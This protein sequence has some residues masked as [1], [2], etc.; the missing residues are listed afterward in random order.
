MP[1]WLPN[2]L[3]PTTALTAAGVAVPAL[4]LLYFLKLRRQEVA[5]SSTLL[6]KKAIQD[7]QVNA[8]FQKLRRNL[9]LILQMLLLVLMLLALA[10]PVINMMRPA[11]EMT[12]ILIDRSASMQTVEEDGRTRLDIAKERARSLVG[13]LD[14]GAS[15]MVIA[16][17]DSAE[18]VQ[19]FT[20]DA[21]A[22]RRAID[23][24]QPTDRPSRLKLA[25]QLAE[26]QSNF[27]PEQL[28][29]NIRPDVFVFSDGRVLDGD[30]LRITGEVQYERIG[31]P[32]TPNVGIVAMSARRNYERPQEVQVFARLANY[33]PEVVDADVQFSVAMIDPA[34]P[35]RL[36]YQVVR[37][38][39]TTLIP[40]H[41]TPEQR[42]QAE[43]EGITPRD[44]VEFTLELTTAGV[45]RLQHLPRT[46]DALAADD[47]A[48]VVVPPP[49]VLRVALVTEGNYF[50]EK[51]LDSLNLRDPV[52][53]T[54]QAYERSVGN[55]ES[56][57][58]QFD[59]IIF[60]RYAPPRPDLLPS[61]GNFLW[62]GA[63]PD[64]LGLKVMQQ[65]GQPVR[66]EDV[67]VLDWQRDHPMLRHLSLGRLY[68]A[69]ALRFD[70]PLETQRLIE[71]ISGP[72]VLL[73]REGRS[74]H[75]VI[76]FDLL[77][78]NWPLRVS[79]PVF[80]YN[81]MQ[82]LALGSDMS[83]R[84]SFSPG[85]T[86]MIPRSVVQRIAAD[87]QTVR[88]VGPSGSREITVPP[89]GDFALPALN[90]VGI[91]RLEPPIPQ[92]EQIAVNLLDPNESNLIPLDQPPGN[93]G[94]VVD[95][96][97]AQT[98][99]DLWWWIIACVALPLLLIEWWVYTRRVHL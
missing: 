61:A 57:P 78:S 46:R 34:E 14:R 17:D 55:P 53:M 21:N 1:S 16:F 93:I 86:P 98:R 64:H 41:W 35:G 65:D 51:A 12:V 45:I 88:L 69:E 85:A 75:L 49:K 82:Y 39:D 79:F 76:G 33:G 48:Q 40:E 90:Q 91:Y 10:R 23:A 15:A 2:L 58:S 87:R 96:T 97:T 60:D 18:P 5:I 13:T 62:I 94:E 32:D 50:L 66:I 30:E 43:R 73:H 95:A 63:L 42:D 8:P 24:I 37:L 29:A 9:L 31:S 25:Y 6:W 81:A 59:V 77:Q 19:T 11:G 54:P 26:A 74:T 89:H 7:L 20:T 36:S 70:V 92:Y 56:D 72:L 99:V 83:V 52:R 68:V 47:V 22:L 67:G 38:D 44:A 4:L 27:N 84:E 28:R 71:G 80:M 3:N